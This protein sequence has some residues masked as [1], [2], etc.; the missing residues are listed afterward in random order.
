MESGLKVE[1]NIYKMGQCMF[2]CL[3]N[4]FIMEFLQ[5]NNRKMAIK[6]LFSYKSVVK[7]SFIARFT[8]NTVHSYGPQT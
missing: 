2:M 8:Y 5:R 6:W 3:P 1:F 4:F 7:L